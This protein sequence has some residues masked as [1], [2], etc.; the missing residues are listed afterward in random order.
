MNI[1]VL[2]SLFP[3]P[4][5]PQK[6]IFVYNM[7]K[8]MGG[9]VRFVVV[10]P[11]PHLPLS[12]KSIRKE[13]RKSFK[14]KLADT[15]PKVDDIIYVD[16]PFLPR[17]FHPLF[18]VFLYHRLRKLFSHLV[19]QK[20]FDLLHSHFL[21]PEGVISAKLGKEFSIK[22]ICTV[23]GSDLNIIAQRF[24][25]RPFLSYALNN[26]A[27][28]VFVSEALKERFLIQVLK[29]RELKS[30]DL[31][32]I[33]NGFA[34]WVTPSGEPTD[35][36]LVRTLREQKK[37]IIL[38]VGNL[39]KVKRPDIALDALAYLIRRNGCNAVLVIIGEGPKESE[40]KARA[41]RLGLREGEDLILMGRVPHARVLFWM[42]KADVLTLT[43]D[44]E[45]MP[46][47]ILESLNLGTPVVATLTGGVPEVVLDGV[48]GFLCRRGDPMDVATHLLEA[49]SRSWNREELKA[50]VKAY[51]WSSLSEQLYHYYKLLIGVDKN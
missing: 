40:I 29:D 10:V 45:G 30:L 1:L 28:L 23:H 35:E 20:N 17:V 41:A 36:H 7:L 24:Y 32:V 13:L 50:S 3:T 47:V 37:R 31:A 11:I 15:L 16:Y 21:F 49:L 6:G 2:T 44:N 9:K 46:S 51:A 43:S 18:S 26:L 19:H 12:R 8:G 48:N 22:S 25:W 27:G 4:E 39:I 5:N 42:E 34:D 14:E 33:P 38:F